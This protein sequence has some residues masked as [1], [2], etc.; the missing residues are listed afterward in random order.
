MANASNAYATVSPINT[1]IG[2]TINNVQKMDLA[3]REEQRKL[4]E[5]EDARTEK[6]QTKQDE[7]KAFIMGKIPKNFDTGSSSLNE[8]N[9]KAIQ[10]GVDRIGEIYT[11]LNNP[12]ITSEDRVKLEL[13]A[14]E[15]GDLP[16]KLKLATQTFTETINDYQEKK[17]KGEYFPD[18]DFE[19]KV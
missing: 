17:L 3:Y 1:S 9:A 8:L 6:A 13:E 15:I 11:E 16:N 4:K 2:D 14:Q 12:N 19:K 10:K 18:L 7:L 5:I